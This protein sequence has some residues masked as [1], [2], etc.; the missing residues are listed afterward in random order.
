M[1]GPLEDEG[2]KG[3]DVGRAG[4]GGGEESMGK[5]AVGLKMGS[6][7]LLDYTCFDK[8]I[9]WYFCSICGVRC[10]DFTGKSEL[11]TTTLEGKEVRAWKPKKEGWKENQTGYLSI[12]ACTLEQDQ[13]GLDLR[14]W[15][16]KR[17]IGYLDCKEEVG[18]DRFG[19]PYPGGIY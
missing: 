3:D 18:E 5:G 10:F 15:H 9:H 6:G 8:Q 17:W 1:L 7:G 19:E 16:E 11:I 14:E 13:E 2:V 12:N 4:A